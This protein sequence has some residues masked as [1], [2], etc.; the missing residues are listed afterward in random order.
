MTAQMGV[1][2]AGI[3]KAE[4]DLVDVVGNRPDVIRANLDRLLSEAL[5]DFDQSSG[6]GGGPVPAPPEAKP[7]E[8][9]VEPVP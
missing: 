9:E 3:K 7:A 5:S 2:R 1:L 6:E 8:G 4:T